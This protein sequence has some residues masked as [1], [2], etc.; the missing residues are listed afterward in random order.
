MAVINQSI[1]QSYI[2]A[3]VLNL[4]SILESPGELLKIP[5]PKPCPGPIKA[6]PLRVSLGMSVLKLPGDSH[7]E[8]G[9]RGE[10]AQRHKAQIIPCH[11]L[12][13]NIALNILA[14]L[15]T[16]E[17]VSSSILKI[18]HIWLNTWAL[19]HEHA[20]LINNRYFLLLFSSSNGCEL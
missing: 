17:L 5:M 3:V 2:R 15:N 9:Q 4:G 10:C 12:A 18:R 19:R 16:S 14:L 8:R 11:L 13:L 20:W 7:V 6:E 1:N